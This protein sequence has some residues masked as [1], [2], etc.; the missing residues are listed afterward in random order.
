ME[1]PGGLEIPRRFMR[2]GVDD[3][4]WEVESAAWLIEHMCR[5]VGL[6]DLRDTELLDM[7]CGVKFTRLFVNHGLAIKQYVGVDVY[8]EM[9]EFLQANVDDPRFEHLHINVKNDLYN[10][11]G[12]P[13]SADLRLPLGDRTFDLICLFSVFTHL[14]PEDYRTMLTILR[15]HVRPEGTLF[16]SLFIDELTE[17]GH[18]LMDSWSR[19]LKAD[20]RWLESVPDAL[21]ADGSRRVEKFRELDPAR[22][23]LFAVYSEDFA[24]ELIEETGWSVVKLSLPN[25]YIQP[26]FVCEPA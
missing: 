12:D 8:R 11:E 10:P 16:F 2:S 20:P 19:L 21:N 24:R 14:P 13:F 9:I 23:G 4:G 5:E 3:E 25:R 18:G 17:G 15:R 7:G 26:S 6:T 22:P 1:T